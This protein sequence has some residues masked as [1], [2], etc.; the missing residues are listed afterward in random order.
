MIADPVLHKRLQ[1]PLQPSQLTAVCPA[2]LIGGATRRAPR[3]TDLSQSQVTIPPVN[4]RSWVARSNRP[5]A[6]AR[7]D[8]NGIAPGCTEGPPTEETGVDASIRRLP[9]ITSVGSGCD[10]GGTNEALTPP[11]PP[12]CR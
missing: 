10:K 3:G 1:Q 7:Q 6:P 2:T 12:M 5:Y 11:P 8:T 9:V 4:I